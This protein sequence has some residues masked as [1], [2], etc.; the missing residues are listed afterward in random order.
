M[1]TLTIGEW[2]F[3]YEAGGLEQFLERRYAP[4]CQ[5]CMIP[6]QPETLR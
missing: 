4:G 2:Q 5:L 3:K 6:D 1:C